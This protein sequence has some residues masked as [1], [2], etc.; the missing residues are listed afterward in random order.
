MSN[1]VPVSA[2]G[3]RHHLTP[4]PDV[5]THPASIA[6]TPHRLAVRT[7]QALFSASASACRVSHASHRTAGAGR[8]APQPALCARLRRR[9]RLCRHAAL[10]PAGAQQRL[11]SPGDAGLRH[12]RDPRRRQ[13]LLPREQRAAARQQDQD[14]PRRHGA[15]H[16]AGAGCPHHGRSRPHPAGARAL[17]RH[18]HPPLGA[19]QH[20]E[21]RQRALLAGAGHTAHH[22]LAR[23]L[24]GADRGDPPG[25][26]GHRTGGVRARRAVHRL[27]RALPALRLLQ[28]PRR[29]PGGVHQLLPLGLHGERRGR[30]CRR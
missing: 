6:A 3:L 29:Q 1:I 21:P 27:L 4:R 11:P 5:A 25:L 28:P 16:R 30:G 12:T 24:P 15:G 7:S 22:P 26:P 2:T 17:A 23:T 18:G 9:C 8:H 14:L 19:G 10:Q 20:H 13:S